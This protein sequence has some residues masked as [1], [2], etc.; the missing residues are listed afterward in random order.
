MAKS[1][2][3]NRQ[4]ESARSPLLWVLLA[5][6]AVLFTAVAWL[7]NPGDAE[8]DVLLVLPKRTLSGTERERELKT[9][10]QVNPRDANSAAELTQIYIERARGES[11]PRYLGYALHVLSPWSDSTPPPAPIQRA[12]A[13]LL[14][15]QHRFDESLIDLDN[16][17]RLN[18]RDAQARL[19]RATVH[20]VSGNYRAA[21]R[22]CLQL[23]Q[24]APVIGAGCTASVL[25]L[26]GKTATALSLLQKISP[27][28]RHQTVAVRQWLL[29][30]HAEAADRN[31][32]AGVADMYFRRALQ[33]P[34]RNAY[35]LRSYSAFLLHNDQ[36]Q[37][38]IDLLK[39]ETGDDSLLLHAALA[40]KRVGDTSRAEKYR[41]AIETRLRN[42]TLRGSDDH[43][44]LAARYALEFDADTEKALALAQQNWSRSKEVR[45]TELLAAVAGL[46]QDISTIRD[47]ENWMS[48][49][50]AELPRVSAHLNRKEVHTK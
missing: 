6:V 13:V 41:Q 47:I 39:S 15:S 42:A 49:Q 27:Q 36:P 7:E 11:D 21:L 9:A 19:T 46:R 45:D 48:E 16:V 50:G 37:R 4:G 20:Q 29:S 28:L 38:V 30:I 32:Q 1:V 31:G 10:L 12:R 17:L 3:I 34:R 8:S 18:P 43:Y 14:Q 33:E 40:A 2:L 26:T 22:D 24:L 35:L 44:Y 25:S 23:M 5:A